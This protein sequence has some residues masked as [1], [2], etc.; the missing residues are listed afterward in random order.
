METIIAYV[1]DAEYALKMLS[2]LMPTGHAQMSNQATHWVIVACTPSVTNDV[3]KWVSSEA[4][5]LW[6]QDWAAAVFEQIKPLVGKMG[7]TFSTQLATQQD[8]LIDQTNQ[9]LK[10]HCGA[11]V[12]DA[13]RPKFGQDLQPITN[14]QPLDNKKFAGLAAAVTV[15]TVLAADF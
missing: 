8:S 15:A 3:G 9:L 12:I 13:R 14:T 2:P 10:Q 11:K 5:H 4:K 1:D 6:R 7:N